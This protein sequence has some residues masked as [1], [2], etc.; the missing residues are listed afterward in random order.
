[1][2]ARAKC[3][4]SINTSKTNF[5]LGNIIS[6]SEK[7][8]KVSLQRLAKAYKDLQRLANSKFSNSAEN[9]QCLIQYALDEE[10][11]ATDAVV[12]AI[13]KRLHVFCA[14]ICQKIKSNQYGLEDCPVLAPLTIHSGRQSSRG[15]Y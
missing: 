3:F 9:L 2:F 6:K 7:L 4:F 11:K 1:M 12:F 15:Y 10:K 8:G 13:K 14:D 5:F